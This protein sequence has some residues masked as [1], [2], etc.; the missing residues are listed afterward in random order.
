MVLGRT[1][2]FQNWAGNCHKDFA[3]L[4]GDAGMQKWI[5]RKKRN[6]PK[7]PNFWSAAVTQQRVHKRA[8]KTPLPPAAAQLTRLL[9]DHAALHL[10]QISKD[11]SQFPRCAPRVHEEHLTCYQ[12]RPAFSKQL[13]PT[14]NPGWKAH[15]TTGNCRLHPGKQSEQKA[16][17]TSHAFVYYLDT[18][19]ASLKGRTTPQKL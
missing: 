13:F 6:K 10:S 8:G 18:T 4:V 2:A 15:S 11:S 14:V 16:Q 17:S 7:S 9:S 12:Q 19:A 5:F 1:Q 3:K